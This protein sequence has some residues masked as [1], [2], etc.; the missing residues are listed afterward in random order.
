MGFKLSIYQGSIG[1]SR[2]RILD[3]PRKTSIQ[4]LS[5]DFLKFQS[6]PIK[7]GG[8][9]NEWSFGW[10]RPLI[11]QEELGLLSDSLNWDLSDCRIA[12]GVLLRM[13]VER[14]TV[15]SHLLQI[16]IRERISKKLAKR[17]KP[18]SKAERKEI[19]DLTKEELI[20][21]ALPAVSFVDGYWNWQSKQLM[22][23]TT[24]ARASAM[25]ED[26]FKVSFAKPHSL[27][28]VKIAPPLLGLDQSYW[29]KGSEDAADQI[30]QL[31]LTTPV[32]FSEH[33]S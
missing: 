15:P 30:K 26:L 8:V 9:R 27:S 10:V 4:E 12:D 29:H 21:R 20:E 11:D 6:E 7:L 22:L 2:Y 19:I 16:V 13:R 1:V 33:T 25:F 17:S 18:L 32:T 14:R 3:L 28:M 31:S 23:Y 24:A 5:K